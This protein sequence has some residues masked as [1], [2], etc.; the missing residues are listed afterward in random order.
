[1]PIHNGLVNMLA[2]IVK[3]P[4]ADYP[5]ADRPSSAA[6]TS[7]QTQEPPAKKSH[8]KKVPA[9]AYAAPASPAAA[10]VEQ[11]QMVDQP[12]KKSHKKKVAAPPST[13][14]TAVPAAEQP[15]MKPNENNVKAPLDA[16]E[17]SGP[18]V[19]LGTEGTQAAGIPTEVKRACARPVQWHL[20]TNR[21][22]P[23]LKCQHERQEAMRKRRRVDSATEDAAPAAEPG[24]AQQ[25][26]AHSKVH[27]V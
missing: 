9:P 26:L 17:A 20:R 1:M 8:K 18:A 15:A 12:A 6:T 7:G 27:R 5:G 22:S 21:H 3:K 14:D 13:S 16:L 2:Q 11:A 4:V 24:Q 25:E 10:T 23:I 19:E